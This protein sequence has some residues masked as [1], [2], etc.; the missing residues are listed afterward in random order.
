VLDAVSQGDYTKWQV[1]YDITRMR[2]AFRTLASH[3]IKTIA[4]TDIDFDHA[5]E[6]LMTDVNMDGEGPILKRFMPYSDDRNIELMKAGLDELKKTGIFE[7]I[8][9]EHIEAIIS[10]LSSTKSGS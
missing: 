9:P 6:A 4:L 8:K 5:S 1:V 7:Q 10:A 2:I 3:K